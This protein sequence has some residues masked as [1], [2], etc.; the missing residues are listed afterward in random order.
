M[1]IIPHANATKAATS[2]RKKH[3]FILSAT[4]VA[5]GA[6]MSLWLQ[7][8]PLENLG[9]ENRMGKS[10]LFA[11]WDEGDV[12][13][14]VRHAER[15]DRSSDPCLG[16]RS[17]ITVSGNAAADG[18]GSAFKALGLGNVD[19]F[20]SPRLRTVQ[21][22]NSM[23]DISIATRDWLANCRSTLTQNM[24]DHKQARRNL[25]LVTHSGCI[26]GVAKALGDSRAE[27]DSEYASALFVFVD[28]ASGRPRLLGYMNAE[29]L[30]RFVGETQG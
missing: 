9:E 2:L 13:V 14:L 7:R 20:A 3:L 8:E 5:L 30:Q 18:V 27:H 11:N 28:R 19:I 10:G 23:F 29:D 6:L 21:T 4:L 26:E 1:P 24:L 16:D 15:C 12:V 22:A 25:L 17:G